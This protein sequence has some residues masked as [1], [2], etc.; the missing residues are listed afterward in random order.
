M[1][2]IYSY[3]KKYGDVTFFD[4]EFNDIDS[5]ILSI[6]TYLEL[7][8]IVSTKRKKISLNDAIKMFIDR[9]D[10]KGF[11]KRGFCQKDIYKVAK[12]VLDT[13]RYRDIMLYNYVYKVNL[14]EQFSAVTM[15][16][17]NGI[18]YVGF[19]GTDHN[20]VGWEEDAALCYKYPVLAQTDA[21]NY[22]NRTIT[23]FDSN[24][25]VGG[26]SKGGHL[27]LVSSMNA[28]FFVRGKI[29]QIHN[30]DGPGLRKK[31]IESL[32]YQRIKDK[33]L[34]MV[35]NNSFFGML[36]RH[37]SDYV[38]VKSSRRGILAHFPTAWELDDDKVVTTSLS[39]LSKKLEVGMLSWLER[40][41]DEQRETMFRGIFDL[42]KSVGVDSVSDLK[43]IKYIISLI[44][45]A[46][47]LDEE[48]K[49][50]FLNFL[51]FNLDFIFE[52]QKEMA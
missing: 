31:E 8:G 1:A 36:L 17:P 26:H 48:S 2:N 7:D 37:D 22:L 49:E 16:L 35:P 18:T 46:K 21:I 30:F 52:K 44:K 25:I 39:K 6:L 32:N 12:S 51:K 3:I 20:L 38:V 10:Y 28:N 4:K 34:F 24:V 15:K 14:V 42:I 33:Y 47:N 9:V 23:L 45:N 11:I 27:A 5:M 50:L 13:R 40:H 41:N 29:K 43:D 19:E